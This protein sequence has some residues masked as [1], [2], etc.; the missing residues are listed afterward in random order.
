ML[1]K[2]GKATTSSFLRQFHA[3]DATFA[4]FAEKH[5]FCARVSKF[6]KNKTLKKYLIIN[7]PPNHVIL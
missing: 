1:I 3:N 5:Q 4:Y 7:Y 2:F 6:I